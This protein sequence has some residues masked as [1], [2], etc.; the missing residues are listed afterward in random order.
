[1]PRPRAWRIR[2]RTLACAR[3]LHARGSGDVALAVDLILAE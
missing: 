3:R 2:R 1:V